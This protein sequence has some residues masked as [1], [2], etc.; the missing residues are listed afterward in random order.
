MTIAT[1][2][3]RLQAFPPDTTVVV[4]RH[5]D[6]GDVTH[7]DLLNLTPKGGWYHDPSY[8]WMTK[9]DV[10]PSQPCVHITNR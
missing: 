1:L 6:Y 3:A 8:A 2:I 9:G 10:P 4:D 5:S 7:I